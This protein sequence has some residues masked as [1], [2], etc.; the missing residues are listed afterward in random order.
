MP[1]GSQRKDNEEKWSERTEKSSVVKCAWPMG[2]TPKRNLV[3]RCGAPATHVT[4]V[5][6]IAVC[7]I[8][9]HEPTG[10]PLARFLSEFNERYAK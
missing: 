2:L 3:R 5:S 10:I 4:Q 6:K 8:H 9:N 1:Q 7:T